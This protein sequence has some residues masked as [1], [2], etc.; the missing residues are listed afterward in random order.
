MRISTVTYILQGKPIQFRKNSLKV[1]TPRQI[2]FNSFIK[3]MGVYTLLTT[4]YCP[5]NVLH[6]KTVYD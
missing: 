5:T 4:L 1:V 3:L 2:G 6:L